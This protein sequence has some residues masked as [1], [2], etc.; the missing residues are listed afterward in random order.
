MSRYVKKLFVILRS[1]DFMVVIVLLH[2]NNYSS[3]GIVNP[4]S[5][6]IFLLNMQKDYTLYDEL[7]FKM[8]EWDTTPDL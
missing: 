1:L 7:H 2:K 3:F 5:K 6:L 4:G 8:S